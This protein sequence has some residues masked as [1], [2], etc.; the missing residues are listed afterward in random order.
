MNLV[1]RDAVAAD[2]LVYPYPFPLGP[3]VN[4]SCGADEVVVVCPAW[5]VAG[6]LGPGHHQY[7]SP[8]PGKPL[9]VYFVLTGPVE[10]PFDMVS[11]F[12]LPGTVQQITVRATGSVLVRVADPGMLIAQFVGLP[13]DR[14]N[15]G[16]MSS[17]SASVERL[18]GKVLPRKVAHAGTPRAVTDPSMWPSL[19][20]ELSAYNPTTGAVFG[21]QFVR[22]ATLEVNQVG[23]NLQPQEVSGWIGGKEPLHQV[24]PVHQMAPVHQ[25]APVQDLTA[26]LPP[27]PPAPPPPAPAPVF[28]GA[29]TSSSG[30]VSSGAITSSSG[31][32]SSGAITSS[33]GAV[34]SGSI[35]GAITSSSGAVSSG[36]ISSGSISSGSITSGSIGSG[37]IGI[38]DTTSDEGIVD[39]TSSASIEIE[40]EPEPEPA[41]AARQASAPNLPLP[42]TPSSPTVSPIGG[43]PSPLLEPP[44][45]AVG[46]RV[47]VALA[48]GLL[49]SATVRQAMQGYYE[50]DVGGAE[51]PLWVPGNSVAP[52]M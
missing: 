52:Q 49:H 40:P 38:E 11:H 10:V 3:S 29:I 43:M 42:S 44:T 2:Q 41:P 28:A 24:A 22:F 32:V 47:L 12:A 30:A 33:S 23:A 4:V 1:A 13:F 9:S 50:L 51:L 34:S 48:D 35:G 39:L 26:Q 15:Y 25:V 36:S 6:L 19:A 46:S 17:V 18:L 20:E 14:V 45:Y 31:A 16:L 37:S 7:L 8:E 27:T 21:L 5:A